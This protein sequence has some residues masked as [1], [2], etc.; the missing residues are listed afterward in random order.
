MTPAMAHETAAW[1][2]WACRRVARP[3]RGHHLGQ[4]HHEPG[5][6][7]H[8][9]GVG[10]DIADAGLDEAA[11]AKNARREQE[12]GNEDGEADGDFGPDGCELG[13]GIAH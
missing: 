10:L 9:G 2:A 6:E 5:E 1:A 12:D 7:P 13:E 3:L 4:Q 11:G 8:E